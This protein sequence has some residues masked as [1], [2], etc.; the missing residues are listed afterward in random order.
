MSRSYSLS[1]LRAMTSEELTEQ[2]DNPHAI[3]RVR[4]EIEL[5]KRAARRPVRRVI[6]RGG[7]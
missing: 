2:L 3:V 4:A 5:N 6:N 7:L 1:E